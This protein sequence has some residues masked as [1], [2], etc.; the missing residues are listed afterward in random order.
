MVSISASTAVQI[1]NSSTNKSFTFVADA[2]NTQNIKISSE[3]PQVVISFQQVQPGSTVYFPKFKG[4]LW[5]LAVT[6]AQNGYIEF[7][8]D[9]R[10]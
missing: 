3:D 10:A 1:Y 9:P 2:S 8:S 7:V 5:A 4:S 6:S